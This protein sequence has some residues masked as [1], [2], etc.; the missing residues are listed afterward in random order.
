MKKLK[1]I[2]NVLI[3][4][5]ANCS[6]NFKCKLFRAHCSALYCAPLRCSYNLIMYRKLKVSHN[7]I[8]RRSMDVPRYYSARTMFVNSHLDNIDVLIRK[9]CNG[10]KNRLQC[11]DNRIINAI[12]NSYPF[13]MSKL[14]VRWSMNTEVVRI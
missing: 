2:W 7:D 11:S 13:K 3:R 14:Y 5:F 12:V 8:L 1:T 9:Q 4:K 6:L 10:F